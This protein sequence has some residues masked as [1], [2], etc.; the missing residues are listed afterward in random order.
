MPKAEAGTKTDV[1]YTWQVD[2]MYVPMPV[3]L[4][5]CVK[6]I[7]LIIVYVYASKFLI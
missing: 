2:C 1:D 6:R 5:I 7:D 3:G 4:I